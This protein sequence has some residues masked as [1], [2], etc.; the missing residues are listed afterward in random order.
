MKG[1]E[2]YKRAVWYHKEEEKFKN[3]MDDILMKARAVGY[4]NY[5]D[6]FVNTD[7]IK[8][9]PINNIKLSKYLTT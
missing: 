6:Y 4:T 9:K 8:E 2:E 7:A 1:R 3:H 5:P